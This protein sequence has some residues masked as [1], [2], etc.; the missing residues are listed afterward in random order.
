[1]SVSWVVSSVLM[2]T[3]LSRDRGWSAS[4]SWGDGLDAVGLERGSVASESSLAHDVPATS[5]STAMVTVS[6]LRKFVMAESL[7]TPPRLPEEDADDVP[8]TVRRER[9]SV[10]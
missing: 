10:Y 5:S 9:R 7:R 4:G 6:V 2:V 1:M 3:D 8:L